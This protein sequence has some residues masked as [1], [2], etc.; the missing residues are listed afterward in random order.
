MPFEFDAATMS[1]SPNI[2][3]LAA[4]DLSLLDENSQKVASAPDL[5]ENEQA[6][7]KLA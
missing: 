2:T 5:F 7:H 3:R 6:C 1:W 4:N